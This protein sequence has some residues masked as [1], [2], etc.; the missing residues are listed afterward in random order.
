LVF[1]QIV[2]LDDCGDFTLV[3]LAAPLV[4]LIA[5]GSVADTE[6][7]CEGFVSIPV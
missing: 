7:L 1:C 6:V 4:D 2:S 5:E 3:E